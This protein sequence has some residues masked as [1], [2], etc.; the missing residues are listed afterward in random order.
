MIFMLD[1]LEDLEHARFRALAQILIDKDEGVKAF[2]DYIK[3]AFPSLAKRK[4]KR[5]EEMKGLLKSWTDSGPMTVVP[6]HE[7]G[8][9]RSRL[10]TKTTRVE[11][12]RAQQIYDKL[13]GAFAQVR[14]P[15]GPND[16]QR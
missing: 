14:G 8:A 11:G 4:Q 10:K 2:E 1:R 5:E 9:G 6:L 12:A 15:D 3:I 16:T 13:G 7:L